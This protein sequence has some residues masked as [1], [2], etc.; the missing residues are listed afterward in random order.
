MWSRW[1][2]SWRCSQSQRGHH[3]PEQIWFP[4]NWFITSDSE[5][6]QQGMFCFVSF[7]LMGNSLEMGNSDGYLSDKEM[8]RRMQLSPAQPGPPCSL[9]LHH[10]SFLP[11]S[12]EFVFLS[13]HALSR[14]VFS[15]LIDQSG[16]TLECWAV[17]LCWKPLIPRCQFPPENGCGCSALLWRNCS[18]VL[19]SCITLGDIWT[20]THSINLIFPQIKLILFCWQLAFLVG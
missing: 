16:W 1:G 4:F 9:G 19:C 2:H 17:I 11:S 3:F 13:F 8:H 6:P 10:L 7:G 12:E 20:W 15:K 18:A 5:N 14:I